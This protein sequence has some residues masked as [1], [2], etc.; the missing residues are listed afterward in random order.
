MKRVLGYTFLLIISSFSFYLSS[1]TVSF[2]RKRDSIMTYLNSIESSYLVNVSEAIID[3]DKII[4]GLNG[5]KI[6]KD[7]SYNSIKKVGSFNDNLLKYDIIPLKNSLKNN[8]DKYIIQGNKNK[9]M[10]SIFLYIDEY[11]NLDSI[12][13]LQAPFNLIVNDNYL[14]N[15]Q[16]EL[17]DLIIKGYNVLI[18]DS[19][20]FNKL[21]NKYC[22]M[23]FIDDT[24][25]DQ[26]YKHNYYS[27]YQGSIIEN[28]YLNKIKRNIKSGMFIVLKGYYEPELKLIISYIQSKGYK[29]SNLD[30]HLI[31]SM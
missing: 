1:K 31:E 18:T 5:L 16:K 15:H 4:P 8:R 28:N 2:L 12:T 29:I 25:K 21:N 26:C 3:N 24:F 19:N 13:N 10:V 9:N 17:N 14:S 22:F 30:N 23:S 6:N 20:S 27:I 7:K 11:T